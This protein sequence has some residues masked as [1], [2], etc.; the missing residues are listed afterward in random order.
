MNVWRKSEI[1]RQ[2]GGSIIYTGKPHWRRLY[3]F[4]S[5]KRKYLKYQCSGTLPLLGMV[6][7]LAG[8]ALLNLVA[9]KVLNRKK[10]M[11]SI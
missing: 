2:R 10:F 8:K 3:Q 11:I 6:V 4:G 9:N 5:G 7:K 1:S